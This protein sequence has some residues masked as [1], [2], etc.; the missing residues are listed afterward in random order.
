MTLRARLIECNE[1]G[2][3]TSEIALSQQEFLIGR[4]IDCDL[5]LKSTDIS[6]HHCI[7]RLTAD[8]AELVDLGSQ[9]GTFLKGERVRSQAEL[10]TG[11]KIQLGSFCYV[12]DLGDRDAADLR[13]STPAPASTIV[14]RIP[15][16]RPS[17]GNQQ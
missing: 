2:E 10:H 13:A 3:Q 5:R 14:S 17:A 9:N 6:R 15:L 16:G 8:K 12:M 11:D 4:G 1:K 7:I